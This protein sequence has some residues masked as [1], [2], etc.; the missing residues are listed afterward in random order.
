M[1]YLLQQKWILSEIQFATILKENELIGLSLKRYI[2]A[3][4]KSK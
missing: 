2:D 3:I 4:Y 1:L